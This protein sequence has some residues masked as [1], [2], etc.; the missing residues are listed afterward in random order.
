MANAFSVG[1]APGGASYAAPL[2]NFSNVAAYPA[3]YRQGQAANAFP[4]GIPTDPRTGQ[5][6]VS[7]I[8]TQG[9]KVGGLDFIKGILPY[10][11][12]SGAASGGSN[13]AADLINPPGGGPPVAA[14]EEQDAAP[15]PAR[16]QSRRLARCQQH[17]FRAVAPR[18]IRTSST[19]HQRRSGWHSPTSSQAA[20]TA[21]AG[22]TA[23]CRGSAR[24]RRRL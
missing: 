6:D 22:Q 8:L 20:T 10:M 18:T 7:A 17:S 3:Q 24:G 14:A 1:N 16:H 13:A 21:A 5:P 15:E 11:Y 2:L 19:A 4:N 12:L 9:A 23:P